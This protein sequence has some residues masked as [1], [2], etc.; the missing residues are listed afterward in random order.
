MSASP[1]PRRVENLHTDKGKVPVYATGIID[2]PWEGY[3]ETDHD[4]WRMLYQ[5]QRELLVGRASDEFLVAQDAMGMTPDRI[6]K[7]ADLNAVLKAATGRA[8]EMLISGG[9]NIH[10]LTVESCLAACPGIR[11]VAVTGLRDP[12]W[13]DRI[14]ALV[15]GDATPAGIRAW[16]RTRLPGAAL[17]R[18]I[19]RLPSLPRNATGK[20]E[21]AAL[22][23][24]A[25]EAR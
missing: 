11:D 19:V 17:P 14:V 5:R 4:V 3:S 15:V 10:P 2:Q 13:G 16:C 8:D 25:R 9:S 24:L 18:H 23:Q 12:V 20:L 22:L 21:R 7:F 6:P 1:Q